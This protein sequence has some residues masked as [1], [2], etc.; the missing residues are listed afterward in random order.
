VTLGWQRYEK[1]R[2]GERHR[3]LQVDFCY[4]PTVEEIGLAKTHKSFPGNI[5]VEVREIIP[6]E[7]CCLYSHGHKKKMGSVQVSR[8]SLL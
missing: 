4:N 6:C 5:K 2:E 7:F 1:H 3:L 8:E